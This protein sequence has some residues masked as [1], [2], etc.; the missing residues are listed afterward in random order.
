MCKDEPHMSTRT[1]IQHRAD[2]KRLQHEL[3]KFA[4]I[5]H[6]EASDLPTDMSQGRRASRQ[7]PMHMGTTAAATGFE[8]ARCAAILQPPCG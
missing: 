2:A 5:H 4:S 6:V 1:G 8:P 3:F 7:T